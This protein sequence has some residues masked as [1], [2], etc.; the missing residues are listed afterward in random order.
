MGTL[1]LIVITLINLWICCEG[2]SGGFKGVD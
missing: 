2:F 1:C